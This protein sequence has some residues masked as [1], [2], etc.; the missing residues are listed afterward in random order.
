MLVLMLK[1]E[2]LAKIR[3]KVIDWVG[4]VVG[5]QVLRAA[6]GVADWVGG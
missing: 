4:L 1:I 3:H 2:I 5:M 6:R